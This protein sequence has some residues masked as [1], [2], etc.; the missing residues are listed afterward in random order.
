MSL[1]GF[2]LSTNVVSYFNTD[3]MQKDTCLQKLLPRENVEKKDACHAVMSLTVGAQLVYL[4]L[5]IQFKGSLFLTCCVTHPLC[6]TWEA[7][8]SGR[9]SIQRYILLTTWETTCCASLLSMMYLLMFIFHCSCNFCSMVSH[10]APVP[11]RAHDLHC[12][13][14]AMVLFPSSGADPIPTTYTVSCKF[15]FPKSWQQR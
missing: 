3:H 8:M 5:F 11:F 14:P 10:F 4:A 12:A 6:E 1:I 2:D 7:C 9:Q 15:C 13:P